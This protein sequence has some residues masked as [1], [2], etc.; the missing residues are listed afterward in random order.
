[1]SMSSAATDESSD[2]SLA[3]LDDH[4]RRIVGR[5]VRGG[6]IT[7]IPAKLS[8]RRV[9]LE[10]LVL[11][12]QPDRAYSEQMVNLVI[13]QRHADVAALRRYLVDEGLMARAGGSYRRVPQ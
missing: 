6:R 8:V 5:F 4:R 2:D 3:G 1:M 10:W 9:L 12:F 7:Q 11:D 13:G